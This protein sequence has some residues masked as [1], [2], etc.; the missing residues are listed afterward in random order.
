MEAPEGADEQAPSRSVGWLHR[1]RHVSATRPAL[2]V[3][4]IAVATAAVGLLVR[5]WEANGRYPGWWQDTGDYHDVSQRPLL[6]GRFWAADRPAGV[7]L[8]LK[9]VGE[10]PSF[11][12]QAVNIGVV[13]LAWGW[14]A[15]ELVRSLRVVG[16][17]AVAAAA[18]VLG[19]SFSSQLIL[20]DSQVLSESLAISARCSRGGRGRCGCCARVDAERGA[21]ARGRLP[22]DPDARLQ[23]DQPHRAGRR[24]RGLGAPRHAA[25]RPPPGRRGGGGGPAGSCRLVDGVGLDRPSRTSSRW[26]TSSRPASSV[27]PIVSSG[28]P[29][30]GCPNRPR[31]SRPAGTSA[32]HRSWSSVGTIRSGRSGGAGSRTMARPRGCGSSPSTPRTCSSRCGTPSALNSNGTIRGY[33]GEMRVVPLVDEILWA[34]TALVLFALAGFSLAVHRR[35]ARATADRVDRVDPRRRGRDQCLHGVAHRR[36][37]DA[38]PPPA[39]GVRASPRPRAHRPRCAPQDT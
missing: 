2:L 6:S 7:P 25:G 5:W 27:T 15:G 28:S 19:L 1:A 4:V 11:K 35:R 22:V 13:C 20:W 14:L 12:F 39:V 26:P 10:P 17:R 37:G 38:A 32:P 36:H 30:T 24:R 8:V 29:T 18:V 31:S 3:W 16:W 34:P 9:I 23:R 33:A 21:P